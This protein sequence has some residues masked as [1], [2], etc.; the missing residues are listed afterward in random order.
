MRAVR[1][2]MWKHMAYLTA[3]ILTA[4]FVSTDIKHLR[5]FL[6]PTHKIFCKSVIYSHL[7]E[8]LSNKK[9]GMTHVYVL[10]L[11]QFLWR[12]IY[13]FRRRNPKRHHIYSSIYCFN[14][15]KAFSSSVNNLT[16]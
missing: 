13:F 2:A 16:G 7:S 5:R 14:Q 8:I 6:D 10:V 11:G 3:R 4:H 9:F 1:Y 15:F 12:R